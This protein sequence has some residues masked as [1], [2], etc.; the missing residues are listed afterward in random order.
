MKFKLD[1]N[2]GNRR[3]ERLAKAGHDV[4]TISEQEMT[5]AT[6]DEVYRVCCEEDRAIVTLDLDFSNPMRFPPENMAGIAVIRLPKR[7]DL[8]TLNELVETLIEA[9]ERGEHLEGHLWIVEPGQIRIYE[10]S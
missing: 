2:L 9:L 7:A 4:S 6:D 10:P 1:E 5:S 3:K 8:E